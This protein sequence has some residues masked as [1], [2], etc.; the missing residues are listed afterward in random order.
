[1]RAGG[2]GAPTDRGPILSDMVEEKILRLHIHL[3]QVSAETMA[4]LFGQC[5]KKVPLATIRRCLAKCKCGETKFV[6]QRPL[7]R[8]DGSNRC[9]T[10]VAIDIF[11][12]ASLSSKKNP[13]L[14]VICTWSRFMAAVGLKSRRPEAIAEAIF[15]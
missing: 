2:N 15:A 9:G 1:M 13:F 5:G 7:I 10:H 11:F 14:A 3:G 4:R 12:H 8:V 6:F